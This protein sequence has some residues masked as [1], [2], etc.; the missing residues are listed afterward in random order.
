[1]RGNMKRLAQIKLSVVYLNEIIN[2]EY[3]ERI[4][5]RVLE[6]L[7]KVDSDTQTLFKNAVNDGIEIA[8]FR[9][10][11]TA[12]AP[13]ARLIKPLIEASSQ[14]ERVLIAVLQVWFDSQ[15]AHTE[16]VKVFLRQ[17][18]VDGD[19][20]DH[21]KNVF[22][23]YW[24]H[25]TMIEWAEEYVSENPDNDIN[26]AALLI[27]LLTNAAPVHEELYEDIENKLDLI[28]EEEPLSVQFE[29]LE[30]ILKNMSPDS[31]Q[32]KEF[33]DYLTKMLV[34]RDEIEEQFNEQKQ[35][36]TKVAEEIK[37]KLLILNND[38][39]EI[40]SFLNITEPKAWGVNSINISSSDM[41]L[42]QIADFHEELKKY[43][44][45]RNKSCSTFSE[46]KEKREKLKAFEDN[47]FSL[48]HDLSNT[49]NQHADDGNNTA[50]P[51]LEKTSQEEK[52]QP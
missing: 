30:E 12:K 43:T 2:D 51:N 18:G 35:K 14:V 21:V 37:N 40:L 47:I 4:V 25:E 36:E 19:F 6:W 52:K 17:K 38:H 26:D 10:G 15:R 50:S 23:K 34:L 45:L 8:G 39:A 13:K 27:C 3:R 28:S 11:N 16:E 29:K 33:H 1:M 22:E 7:D 41:L 24:L 49:F 20:L 42:K 32:W 44:S 48:H 9:R 46:E 5:N 31:E